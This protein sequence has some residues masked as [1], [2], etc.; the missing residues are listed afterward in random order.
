MKG[1]ISKMILKKIKES[2]KTEGNNKKKIEN[3]VFLIIISIQ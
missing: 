1:M 3:I 2:M